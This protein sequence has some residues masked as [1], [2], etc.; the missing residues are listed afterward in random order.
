ME[1]D[2]PNHNIGNGI[3]LLVMMSC[4]GEKRQDYSDDDGVLPI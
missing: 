2:Y 4:L 1:N 3:V